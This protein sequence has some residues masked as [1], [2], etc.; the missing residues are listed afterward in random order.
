MKNYFPYILLATA[1]ASCA[2]IASSER[3]G[4]FGHRR[5]NRV[6]VFTLPPEM[7]PYYK[8]HIEYIT[9]HAVDPDKRRYATKHEAVRHFIDLDKWGHYPFGNVPR[10]WT[11]ALCAFTDIYLVSPDGDSTL[12]PKPDSARLPAYKQL[13]YRHILPQYYEE[14]WSIPCDSLSQDLHSPKGACQTI[15]AFD[16]FSEHGILPYHLLHMQKK[17]TDAFRQGNHAAILRLSAEIGH[18][19]G[20]AAV[21]LHTTENYNGQLTNQ[22][23]IHAFWESRLPELFADASYD[24]LVGPAV[25]I[26]NPGEFYWNLVLESHLL[27]D[28]VLSVEKQLS[29]TYPADQQFCYEERLETLIKTQCT[30][31]AAAYHQRLDG[32]VERRMRAAIRA[33]GSAWFTAWVDAGQPDLARLKDGVLSAAEQKERERMEAAF[34]RG[35]QQGRAHD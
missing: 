12:L 28:S 30:P 26:R 2:F 10:D 24:Y 35:K 9:E 3:W 25:Y 14:N 21:P 19:I 34:L 23:G 13:F 6:A 22:Q 4:F 33:T 31:Y 27:L 1:L 5:I 18:Y 17:L 32:Q 11:E 20:D 15:A 29:S 7:L 8:K 16:R